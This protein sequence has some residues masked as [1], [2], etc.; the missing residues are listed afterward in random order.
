M[1]NSL[2]NPD[3]N[4]EKNDFGDDIDHS[5]SVYEM[6]ILGKNVEVVLGRNR[7][8][9]GVA[10]F[11]AYVVLKSSKVRPV[12]VF[13]EEPGKLSGLLDED[14]DIDVLATG[15]S[16]LSEEIVF[17]VIPNPITRFFLGLILLIVL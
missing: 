11:V 3:I 1:V 6:D 4:Y 13:E 12:G 10:Y 16:D 2:I 14:G 5:S 15:P 8:T 7:E 9:G 17:S